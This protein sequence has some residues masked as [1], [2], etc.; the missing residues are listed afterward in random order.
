ME[1]K[2]QQ[3]LR[4][5]LKQIS[6]ELSNTPLTSS[7][8]LI[9]VMSLAIG[10]RMKLSDLMKVTGC[11]KGSIEN[12]ILKLEE[13]GFIKTEKVSFFKSPRVYA[14]LTDKGR[15]FYEN[16]LELIGKFLRDAEGGKDKER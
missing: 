9:I 7:S 16:Y 10:R 8:R 5:L 3:G 1:N 12:H 13:G 6:V 11:G 2:N 14:E 4:D 15:N